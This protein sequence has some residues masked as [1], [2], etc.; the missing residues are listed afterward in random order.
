[1]VRKLI[2]NNPVSRDMLY[3]R[4]GACADGVGVD[5]GHRLLSTM[6]S[7]QSAILGKITGLSPPSVIVNSLG[8]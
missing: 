7:P 8:R 6:A 3:E 5:R 2:E 4:H 1:M